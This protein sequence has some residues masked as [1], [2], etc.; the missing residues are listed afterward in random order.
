M[1]AISLVICLYRERELLAR[2]LRE[3]SDCYDDL[4]V[5][6]DGPEADGHG[7]D[8]IRQLV[9]KAGGRFFV[10]PRAFQQEPHWPRAWAE[11]RHDWILRL[12]ADEYPSCELRAW[13]RSFRAGPEPGIAGYT[14]VWPLWDGRRRVTRHWP[15][16]RQF[17]FHKGRVR[18]FGMVEQVPIPEGGNEP[19][20]LLLEHRPLRKS[21]GVANLLLRK[22]AYHWR[23]VI[24]ES[25]LGK[26]TD[27]ACWRWTS[28][29]WPEVWDEI[30]RQP[31]RSAVYR[32]IIWPL[33]GFRD[34]W[35]IEGRVI[36]S[37]AVSGGVHHFLICLKF[38]WLRRQ[39]HM[40]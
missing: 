22:Q 5:V 25:L 10:G 21:Y 18:F 35:R 33:R 2:L 14:C 20:D 28:E 15:G 40:A 32:L 27:L 1:P 8:G 29:A 9:E 4:V 24:A 17:L 31:L 13:L 16:G 36:P 19:L 6:H 23:R 30:R 3:T 12:D 11:A 26:P 38:W 39:R 34:Q 7:E 37:A